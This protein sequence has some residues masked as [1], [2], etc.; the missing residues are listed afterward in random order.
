[1]DDEGFVIRA[2]V[3]QN[4]ILQNKPSGM[5]AVRVYSVCACA[6]V[7]ACLHTVESISLRPLV[8]MLQFNLVHLYYQ[9]FD[10]KKLT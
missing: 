5:D 6:E 9:P 4:D 1:V 7:Y 10:M 3:N 8:I 2:D